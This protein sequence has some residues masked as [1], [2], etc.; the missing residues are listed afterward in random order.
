MGLMHYEVIDN[1]QTAEVEIGQSQVVDQDQ[2]SRGRS[3]I[4]PLTKDRTVENEMGTVQWLTMDR[5]VEAEMG[6]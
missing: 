4:L 2:N 3:G 6:Y 5:S 1:E